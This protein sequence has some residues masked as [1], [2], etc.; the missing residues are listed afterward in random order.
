MI[1]IIE[2]GG[3]GR[4]LYF[5]HAN[6]FPPGCYRALLNQLSS[7][8]SVLAMI[9]RPLWEGSDPHSIDDWTPLTGDLIQFLQ[10]R[11]APPAIVV[12]HS[13]GAMVTLRAALRQPGRFAAI[14]LIE[15]VLFPPR[16]IL[17]WNLVR[18]IGLENRHPLIRAAQKRR[19][20]FDDLDRVFRAYRQRTTFRYMD[21]EALRDYIASIAC[22]AGGA[23]YLLCYS[24]AWETRI[25]ATGMWHDFDIWRGLPSLGVPA[26][27]LR[28]AGTD[29]FWK[30][31][32]RR[33][34]RANPA[35]QVRTIDK[36][37]HL[38]PL[39]R[40][41]ETANLIRDFLSKAVP[42]SGAPIPAD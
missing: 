2:F 26:L 6:G 1:P 3:T 22:P 4:L 15:P 7:E 11:Q 28:G 24:V 27:I 10:E 25:Y 41:A 38:V 31:T 9:Q 18:R 19:Q 21:D 36:A 42:S 30:S 20:A 13:L 40:P 29:T 16:R 17:L 33:V 39:E 32:G 14:V 34:Q 23:G 5:L 35:I 37:T 8:F 12:G